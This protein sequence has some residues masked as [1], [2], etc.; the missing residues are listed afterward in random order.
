MRNFRS[1]SLELFSLHFSNCS[2]VQLYWRFSSLAT[3]SGAF[4]RCHL[5]NRSKSHARVYGN[6]FIKHLWAHAIKCVMAIA[7][8]N[9]IH[10]VSMYC[11]LSNNMNLWWLSWYQLIS[12]VTFHCRHQFESTLT[13]TIA[14]KQTGSWWY[15]CSW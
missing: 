14:L 9:L 12:I 7:S 4:V 2:I 11:S 1:C 6:S 13:N 8:T 3:N 10:R 15:T 5:K